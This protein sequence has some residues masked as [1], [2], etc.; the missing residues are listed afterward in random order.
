MS[1]ELIFLIQEAPEGGYT[2]EALGQA[3]FTEADTYAELK[4]QIA[5]AVRCHFEPN[6]MCRCLCPTD[7][8]TARQR[9]ITISLFSPHP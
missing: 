9:H 3:I 4:I 8:S 2:A 1:T 7:N 5:D 6:E